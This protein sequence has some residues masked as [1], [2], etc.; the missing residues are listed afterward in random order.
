MTVDE[1]SWKQVIG[2]GAFGSVRKQTN[3]DTETETL[4][5]RAGADVGTALAA[6]RCM[7]CGTRRTGRCTL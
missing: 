4:D 7:L 2:R 6:C 1:F 5:W 3:S